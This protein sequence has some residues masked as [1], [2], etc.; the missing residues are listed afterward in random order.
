MAVNYG[1]DTS[2]VTDVG[3]VDVQVTGA[4]LIA[5]RVARLLQTPRGALGIIG[6]DPSRGFD[7]RSL[8]LAKLGPSDLARAK[9]Q[10]EAECLKD[11]QVEAATATLSLVNGA[12]TISVQIDSSEGPFSFVLTVDEV[13]TDLIFSFADGVQ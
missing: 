1:Q 10:I 8:V 12:L 11:E 5:Q 2:C 6:D 7:V 9:S 4:T 13:T 3:L